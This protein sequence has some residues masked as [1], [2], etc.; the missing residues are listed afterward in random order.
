[1]FFLFA[2]LVGTGT[3]EAWARFGQSISRARNRKQ[4]WLAIALQYL[5]A[6]VFLGYFLYKVYGNPN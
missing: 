5:A 1:M 6:A 4:F 3:D 2:A